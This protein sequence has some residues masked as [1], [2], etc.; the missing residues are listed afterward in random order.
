[1]LKRESYLYDNYS[2][3]FC[4]IQIF[5]E[6]YRMQKLELM[7]VHKLN[8]HTIIKRLKCLKEKRKNLILLNGIE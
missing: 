8:T 1:M 6:K 4:K 3:I 2:Y 5:G 7:N